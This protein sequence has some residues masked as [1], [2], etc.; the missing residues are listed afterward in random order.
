M[1]FFGYR[2]RMTNRGR[3]VHTLSI[4]TGKGDYMHFRPMRRAAR[5]ADGKTAEAFLSRAPYGMLA[6]TGDGGYP[7]AVPL[8]FVY[9]DGCIYFHCAKE[10]HKIDAIQKDCRVCFCA[11]ARAE[12]APSE[13]TTHFESVTAFGR[14]HIVTD[15]TEM[16]RAA[17]L[18]CEKHA[19]GTVAETE[20]EYER[21]ANA[22]C[23]VKIEIEHLTAKSNFPFSKE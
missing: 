22:L 5:Q 13:Y 12:I 23:I 21:F 7:Y 14:A 18:L 8:N 1:R 15:E 2:L 16:H 10:G 20:L 9:T 3:W 11:V 6:V 19:C 17:V 4:K